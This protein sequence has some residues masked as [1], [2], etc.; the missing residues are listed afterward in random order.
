MTQVQSLEAQRDAATDALDSA[1][2]AFAHRRDRY[3]SGLATSFPM[4]TAE[5]TLLQA[6]EALVGGD[7]HRHAAAHHPDADGGR[8]FRAG[9]HETAR[10]A[11]V[12]SVENHQQDVRHD[13]H[14]HDPQTRQR[15]FWFLILGAVVLGAALIYGVYWLFMRAF[16]KHR[17]CLC[18]RQC[19]DHH[20]PENATVMALHADNTQSVRRGQLLIEMD[21]AIANVNLQAA[22]ANLARV[23]RN[24]KGAILQ[25]RIPGRLS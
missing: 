3:R 16:R 11:Q 1:K 7:G 25:V 14:Q 22:Q 12:H 6:R 15:R 24:V 20:Q 10:A 9:A 19:G 23:V 21:P 2:R 18:R 4:L 13:R 8:R 5:S 17:R